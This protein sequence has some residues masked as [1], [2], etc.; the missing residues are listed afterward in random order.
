MVFDVRRVALIEGAR[1]GECKISLVYSESSP[2]S[3]EV[4]YLRC[5]YD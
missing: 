5:L 2:M 3:G 1:E 4:R